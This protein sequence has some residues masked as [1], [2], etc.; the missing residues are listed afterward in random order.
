MCLFLFQ[1]QAANTTLLFLLDTE[2]QL[3]PTDKGF[4]EFMVHLYLSYS[5]LI[6]SESINKH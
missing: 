3:F 2:L 6:L 1:R 5:L 4:H